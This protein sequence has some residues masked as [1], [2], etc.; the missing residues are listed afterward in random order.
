MTLIAIIG[1]NIENGID[2]SH[3]SNSQIQRGLGVVCDEHESH[4]DARDLIMGNNAALT[5]FRQQRKY[6][7][8]T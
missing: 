4:N 2:G 3:R 1:Q 6:M 7:T 8:Q 5:D